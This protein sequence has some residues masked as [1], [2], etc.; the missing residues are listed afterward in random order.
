MDAIR[1]LIIWLVC[2]GLLTIGE[3]AGL[4]GFWQV[5]IVAVTVGLLISYALR[6]AGR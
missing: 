1:R 3:V 5:G 2:I 4:S 6:K